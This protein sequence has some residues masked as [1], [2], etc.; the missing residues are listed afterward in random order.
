M[1]PPTMPPQTGVW[2]KLG[3]LSWKNLLL[4]TRH[5]FQTLLDIALPVLAFVLLAFLQKASMRNVVPYSQEFPSL[6]INTL[7]EL[8]FVNFC[9]LFSL[10]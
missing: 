3:L 8:W 2:S 9:F 7:D 4:Q 6:E 5:K 1:A 10:E